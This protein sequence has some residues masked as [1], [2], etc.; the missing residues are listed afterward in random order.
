MKL[1]LESD[2]E[3]S[4]SLII[5]DVKAVVKLLH[6][7]DTAKRNRKSKNLKKSKKSC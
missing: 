5:S 4:I 2:A 3:K 7:A 1:S 6:S